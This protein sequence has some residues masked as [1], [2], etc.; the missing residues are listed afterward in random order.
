MKYSV[1][2]FATDTCISEKLAGR[3][4]DL[5]YEKDLSAEDFSSVLWKLRDWFMKN[6]MPVIIDIIFPL[7][8]FSCPA[9][10]IF[11][12]Y[13]PKNSPTQSE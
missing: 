12:H 10:Y 3:I 5:V 9:E 7:R 1:Q 6:K 4:L 11:I 13:R 2:K 8:S